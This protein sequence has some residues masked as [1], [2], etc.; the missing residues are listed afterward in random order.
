MHDRRN[1]ALLAPAFECLAPGQHLGEHCAE[2]K[3]IGA[4]VGFDAV[5][6]LG[7]HVLQ[8]SE[9]APWSSDSSTETLTRPTR[10]TRPSA[11]LSASIIGQGLIQRPS[12]QVPSLEFTTRTLNPSRSNSLR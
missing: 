1:Q 11:T 8:R 6:L 5:E 4:R 9:N 7:R 12:D 3:N 10:P 2:R